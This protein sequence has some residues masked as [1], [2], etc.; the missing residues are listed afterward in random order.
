MTKRSAPL[1]GYDFGNKRQY[2]RNVYAGLRKTFSPSDTAFHLLMPSSEGDEIENALAAGFQEDHLIIVD[3]NPAIVAVLKRSY[4]KAIAY[5]I[6]LLD[7]PTRLLSERQHI[8]SANLDLC[9]CISEDVMRILLRFADSKSW[10]N[11]LHI[12][13]TILRGREQP[14]YWNLI[15][16]LGPKFVIEPLDERGPGLITEALTTADMGRLCLIWSALQADG[17][18]T[19]ILH[20]TDTYKSQ[21]STLLWSAWTLIEKPPQIEILTKDQFYAKFR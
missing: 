9:S 11:E 2:R 16:E 7:V 3:K 5:G 8:D 6:D 14:K 19:P 10:C 17:R 12:A 15:Q 1:Y 18:T 13:V 21:K 20:R 4:P